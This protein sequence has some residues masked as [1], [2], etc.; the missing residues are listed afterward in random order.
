[1]KMFRLPQKG[2]RIPEPA[3]SAQGQ[4]V[5]GKGILGIEHRTRSGRTLRNVFL[6]AHC[7]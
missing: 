7:V 5:L 4:F 6:Y 2:L 3:K 1:M